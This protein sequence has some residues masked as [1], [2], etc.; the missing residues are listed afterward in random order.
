VGTLAGHKDGLAIDL[1]RLDTTRINGSAA[2]VTIGPV[3]TN[4]MFSRAAQD[5]GFQAPLGACSSVSYIGTTLDGGI[6]CWFSAHG[7][8]LDSLLSAR[9]V[10]ADGDL[11]EASES[12]NADLFWG[13]CGASASLGIVVSATYKLHKH[14]NVG[15]VLTMDLTLTTDKKTDYFNILKSYVDG[16]FP[17]ELAVAMGIIC[18][19][20]SGMV[21]YHIL[22]SSPR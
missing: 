20:G 22:C 2:T 15:K 1:N 8:I 16:E 5:A 11:V 10:L 12:T 3:V 6:G 9:V 14:L 18:D 21:S 17:P 19:P 13:L 7:V 4:A